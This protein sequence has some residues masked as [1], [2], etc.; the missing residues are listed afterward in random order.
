MEV[1]H[2][3]RN[4]G[5][6]AL[7]DLENRPQA[8]DQ[9]QAAHGD[10]HTATRQE[11]GRPTAATEV[12]GDARVPS[13]SVQHA[14]NFLGGDIPEGLDSR[15]AV[16][17]LPPGAIQSGRAGVDQMQNTPGCRPL[18]NAPKLNKFKDIRGQKDCPKNVAQI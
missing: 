3:L 8:F 10:R 16:S 12:F 17:R 11:L 13:H 15:F 9:V 4:L 1:V 14:L 2:V 5:D 7:G 6:D 18:L